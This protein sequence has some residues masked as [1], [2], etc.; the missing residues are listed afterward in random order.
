[1]IEGQKVV[2]AFGHEAES[3]AA[4]IQERQLSTLVTV[5][6][7]SA[8]ARVFLAGHKRYFIES[9]QLGFHSPSLIANMP[10]FVARFFNWHSADIYRSH[11]RSL[12]LS[13]E[14]TNHVAATPP[15]EMWY[16]TVD[17]LKKENIVTDVVPVSEFHSTGDLSFSLE[18]ASA[19]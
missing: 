11:L 18:H 13:D 5:K 17:E 4:L 6:C 2:Q 9:A 14:F 3:L 7:S 15:N 19:N 10:S 8:C 12:G 16:P 1:M